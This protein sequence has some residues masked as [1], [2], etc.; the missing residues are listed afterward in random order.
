MSSSSASS[1][2]STSGSVRSDASSDEDKDYQKEKKP[3]PR[4]SADEKNALKVKKHEEKCMKIALKIKSKLEKSGKTSEEVAPTRKS[5][6][7]KQTAY[8][9]SASEAESD[10]SDDDKKLSTRSFYS[11]KAGSSLGRTR[12]LRTN[13]K[14]EEPTRTSQRTR[15]SAIVKSVYCEESSDDN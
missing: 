8:V 7:A 12:S 3:R 15:N 9:E 5:E 11:K 2:S 6:R 1:Q 13:V 14:S 4:K 10:E